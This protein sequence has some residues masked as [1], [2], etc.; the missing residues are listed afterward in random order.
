MKYAELLRHYRAHGMVDAEREIARIKKC[1]SLSEAIDRAAKCINYDDKRHSH[2]RRIR[3]S[4]LLQATKS[5]KKY[6]TDFEG[7]RNFDDVLKIVSDN[8]RILGIGDLYRYDVAHRISAYLGFFPDKIY[9]HAG[10]REGA[11]IHATVHNKHWITKSEV[12][13]ELRILSESDIENFLCIYKNNV[14][15]NL[16][17]TKSPTRR[18]S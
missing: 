3:K 6:I 17:S 15:R 18:C 14:I 16:C 11:K 1:D 2:Q 5:L 7:C 13:R 9:L 10:T 12:H 4:A 8:T